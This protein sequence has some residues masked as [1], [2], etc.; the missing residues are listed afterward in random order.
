MKNIWIALMASVMLA[1]CAT[2]AERAEREARVAVAVEQGL[3]TQHYKVKVQMMYPRRGKAVNLT[4]DY[5]LEVRGDT[6]V[7]YL[8]FFGRAYSVPY[9]GGKGFDFTGTI[10]HYEMQKDKKG[11][12]KILFKTDSGEDFITYRLE[13]FTNGRTFIDVQSQSREAIS[14]SG[15]IAVE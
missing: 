9:G 5:A 1:A 7:S 2:P 15:E 8:P 6:V 3:E 13:I 14:Y 12:T 11:R 4:S 10:S